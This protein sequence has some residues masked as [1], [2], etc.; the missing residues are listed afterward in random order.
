VCSHR[1]DHTARVCASAV[2]E[3]ACSNQH[4]HR[5]APMVPRRGRR[6][7]LQ[8][9]PAVLAAILLPGAGGLMSPG[10]PVHQ[11]RHAL[12]RFQACEKSEEPSSS[13]PPKQRFPNGLSL[14]GTT[15][16]RALHKEGLQ[17]LTGP[18]GVPSLPGAASSFGLFSEMAFGAKTAAAQLPLISGWIGSAASMGTAVVVVVPLLKFT[19]IA[20][21]LHAVLT[22]IARFSGLALGLVD[23]VGV[24][25]VALLTSVG[26]TLAAP[27]LKVATMLGGSGGGTAG[28]LLAAGPRYLAAFSRELRQNPPLRRGLGAVY[29]VCWIPLKE[30][31]LFRHLLQKKLTL[32]FDAWRRGSDGAKEATATDAAKD[33]RLKADAASRQRGRLI[34]SILFGLAH[35]PAS[36]AVAPM[37]VSLPRAVAAALSAH[38][39]LGL[40]YERRGLPAALGA[41]AAHNA[42]VSSLHAMQGRHSGWLHGAG[43]GFIAPWVAPA[44]YANAI[45]RARRRRKAQL[46]AGESKSEVD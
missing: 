43:L 30:E 40:V 39:C 15:D 31:F 13:K 29:T 9:C 33:W 27:L 26:A 20:A 28:P 19:P 18:F 23:E 24:I 10:V 46:L 4:R 8:W 32:A 16:A 2:W 11:P 42:M 21:A 14:F 37:V 22:P 12:P 44:I 3:I 1:R 6:T 45:A 7:L 36:R 35:L 25:L 41:H 5:A 38:L 34:A 17:S